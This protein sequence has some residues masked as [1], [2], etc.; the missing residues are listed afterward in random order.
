MQY[1]TRSC[2]GWGSF[3]G[4]GGRP[5]EDMRGQEAALVGPSNGHGAAS[6]TI[7]NGFFSF[8]DTEP[9]E[10]EPLRSRLAPVKIT[11]LSAR[12]FMKAAKD[13]VELAAT[14]YKAMLEWRGRSGVDRPLPSLPKAAAAS[15]DAFYRPRI[16][17]GLDL[18]GR[19]VLYNNFGA[20]DWPEMQEAGVTLEM[21]ARR[22]ATTMEMLM[23][24]IDS[25][26]D[27]MKGHLLM[28]DVGDASA[29][30]F[31]RALDL[32]KTVTAIGDTYYPESLG[33][34]SRRSS[35]AIAP[36]PVSPSLISLKRIRTC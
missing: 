1:D 7:R 24:R 5:K 15:L 32:W 6:E 30:K 22:H 31:L 12:R 17:D 25:T 13:D 3:C 20:V 21:V 36:L 16:L 34:C 10:F 4:F 14:N 29:W 19:P 2:D 33:V 23:A 8:M 18:E 9:D 26:A 27:P 11:D 35:E 28:I